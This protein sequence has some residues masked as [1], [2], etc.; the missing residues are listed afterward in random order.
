MQKLFLTF[1]G[2]GL[3]PK[4]PGTVGSVAAA[5]VGYFILKLFSATT[6]FLA[7]ILISLIA[8]SVI[9]AYEKQS[10]EHDNG[11]IVI[12]EVAGVWLAFVISGATEIQML[13]SLV[14]FRIFDI[15]KP[16]IIGRI[17]R[18]VKGGLGVM[19]DDIVAGFVAGIASSMV[20]GILLKFNLASF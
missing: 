2:A 16:S 9:N 6:L 19:G 18:D 15:L 14:F 17:D 10:G 12:D 3:S 7:T 13:L 5:I 20:Y 8:I 1:F 11:W 4:A